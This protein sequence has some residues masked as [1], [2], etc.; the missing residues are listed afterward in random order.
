MWQI[1][2]RG[3]LHL[4]WISW[5]LNFSKLEKKKNNNNSLFSLKGPKPSKQAKTQ[6]TFGISSTVS[7]ENWSAVLQ[8]TSSNSA[9]I[10]ISSPANA[11]IGRYKLSV[12]STSS[13]SS[14][15]ATLGTFV[16][17]F[18][19]WSSG[20]NMLAFPWKNS[21]ICSLINNCSFSVWSILQYRG[22]T[23]TR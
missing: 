17:L 2:L 4:C 19:P 3:G 6:A 14:S 12:Q 9:S 16:L 10:A 21:L 5:Q 7:K 11:V 18:N 20:M 15:P 13:G 22:W 8:S 23:F 1:H